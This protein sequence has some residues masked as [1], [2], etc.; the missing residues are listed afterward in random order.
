MGKIY[1]V[2]VVHTEADVSDKGF[3]GIEVG[4]PA[5]LAELAKLKKSEGLHVP[6]TWCLQFCNDPNRT[7]MV[8]VHAEFFQER[9]RDGDEVG[10]H[11]HAPDVRD[12][13][14]FIGANVEKLE[15]A[16]FPHPKTHA[17]GWF[18]LAPDLIRSLERAGIEIDAGLVVREG[19]FIM[20]ETDILLQDSSD[21]DPREPSAFRPYHPSR[22]DVS[23]AGDS[24]VVEL[25]VFFPLRGREHGWNCWQGILTEPHTFVDAFKRH[26]RHRHEVGADIVQFYWHPWEIVVRRR[27]ADTVK[28]L[29]WIYQEIGRLDDVEFATAQAAVAEWKK[30][31]EQDNAPE[32]HRAPRG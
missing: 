11:T 5:L 14:Q 23:Q 21:R 29:C 30:I 8:D 32:D 31:S 2:N 24:S 16:G 18:Y 26:W 7:D 25:P 9:L 6:M 15:A 17:P 12:Q 20:P 22:T 10:I 4:L 1:V 3:S 27:V 19:R 13:P 28:N